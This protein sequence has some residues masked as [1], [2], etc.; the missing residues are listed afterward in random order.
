[1][2]IALPHTLGKDELRRRLHS[3]SGELA[4]LMPGGNADV[5]IGWPSEDRMDLSVGAMGKT[6]AGHIELADDEIVFEIGLPPAL[7]FAEPLVRGA[8]EAKT[9][10]LLA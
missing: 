6:V 7:A 4:G 9:R 1:M 8:V 3:R 2:R 5:Q 10:K